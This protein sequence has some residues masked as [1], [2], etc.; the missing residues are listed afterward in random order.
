MFQVDGCNVCIEALVGVLTSL[1]FR[2]VATGNGHAVS[3]TED[4]EDVTIAVALP[5]PRRCS[6][7]CSSFF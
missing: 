5:H 6:S 7:S 4:E 2:V 1:L 3:D